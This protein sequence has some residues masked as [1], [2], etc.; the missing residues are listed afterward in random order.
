MKLDVK[1]DLCDGGEG[2]RADAIPA[3]LPA[4]IHRDVTPW[5]HWDVALSPSSHF[6]T[7]QRIGTP[8]HPPSHLHT[9]P[10]SSTTRPKKPLYHLPLPIRPVDWIPGIKWLDLHALIHLHKIERLAP[11][12]QKWSNEHVAQLCAGES[13]TPSHTPAFTHTLTHTHAHTQRRR[14]MEE[15]MTQKEAMESQLRFWPADGLIH[16]AIFN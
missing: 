5:R 4:P 9:F 10:Y 12:T 16:V 3:A 2:E 13:Y 15:A 1:S 14:H 8:I 7:N 11:S 6:G